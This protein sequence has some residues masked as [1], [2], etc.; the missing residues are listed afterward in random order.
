MPKEGIAFIEHNNN[1]KLNNTKTGETSFM[2]AFKNSSA[3]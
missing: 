3:S 2:K 1:Y